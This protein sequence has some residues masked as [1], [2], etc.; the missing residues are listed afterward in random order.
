LLNESIDEVRY[1]SKSFPLERYPLGRYLKVEIIPVVDTI[2]WYVEIGTTERRY[3]KREKKNFDNLFYGKHEGEV[4][5]LGYLRQ[6]FIITKIGNKK[7][8][9][10][11]GGTRSGV[12]YR[13]YETFTK[14]Y[15]IHIEY[16]VFVYSGE[17][18]LTENERT[19]EIVFN[20]AI[21]SN[22]KEIEKIISEINWE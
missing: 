13:I 22:F 6:P 18:P 21:Q 16:S 9:I 2:E 4:F 17:R 8:R 10:I 12:Y 19:G 7:F 5:V 15:Y 20:D 11:D 1:Y 3:L 14:H